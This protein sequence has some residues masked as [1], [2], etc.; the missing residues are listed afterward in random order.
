MSG[1]NFAVIQVLCPDYIKQS[2]LRGDYI[3]PYRFEALTKTVMPWDEAIG[4]KKCV[5]G[6]EVNFLVDGYYDLIDIT[7]DMANV[8]VAASAVKLFNFTAERLYAIGS[9]IASESA[10]S[11]WSDTGCS[12]GL[13][14]NRT[15][16]EDGIITFALNNV[17][18][19]APLDDPDAQRG[20]VQFV[21][22][23]G[24]W[25]E[26]HSGYSLGW[27]E[28]PDSLTLNASN[29][30][31]ASMRDNGK[32]TTPYSLPTGRYDFTAT[33]RPSAFMQ[34]RAVQTSTS[35]VE[36]VEVDE[37]DCNAP[38]EWYDL[39]GRHIA[40]PMENGVYLRRQGRRTQK[41][42]IFSGN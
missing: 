39:D 12:I 15:D 29:T 18:V 33:I 40:E 22:Q 5:R 27:N 23:L 35:A 7:V 19:R 42:W 10:T 34:F 3:A 17:A 13:L 16:E 20:E 31:S 36:A 24:S 28:K 2:S 38:V 9:N 30:T 11:R 41:V 26:I 25:E 14:M 1:T 32:W 4:M 8:T 37:V 6:Q 21:S